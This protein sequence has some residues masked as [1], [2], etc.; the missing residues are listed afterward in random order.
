MTRP[1][2]VWV[3]LNWKKKKKKEALEKDKTFLQLLEEEYEKEKNEIG[4]NWKYKI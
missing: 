3:P 4:K 2:Q 1:V